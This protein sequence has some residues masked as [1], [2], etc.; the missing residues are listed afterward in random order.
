M[1]LLKASVVASLAVFALGFAFW[2]SP[3][4]YLA[5]D[6]LDESSQEEIS[7]Y[8]KAQF[9][10][11]GLFLVPSPDDLVEALRDSPEPGPAITIHVV[12][13]EDIK[14]WWMLLL[15]GFLRLFV[16]VLLAGGLLILALPV[17][18]TY[19]SRLWFVT[20]VGIVVVWYRDLA[21]AI[22]WYHPWVWS[23]VKASYD[24]AAWVLVGVVLAG[25]IKKT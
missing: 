13:R 22:W 10:E 23:L 9:T 19:A 18:P 8:L 2:W 5:L 25:F 6:R 16:A 11:T 14:P 7:S 12:A 17:L 3:L 24:L 20:R 21:D 1:Q 15:I 4:P